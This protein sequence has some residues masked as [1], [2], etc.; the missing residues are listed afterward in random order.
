VGSILARREA[1]IRPFQLGRPLYVSRLERAQIELHLRFLA[2]ADR[3][4]AHGATPKA[5]HQRI[6]LASLLWF[7]GPAV[8]APGRA[9]YL[10]VIL[11]RDFD[12]LSLLWV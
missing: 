5:S 11:F 12:S 1:H 7:P 4:L 2:A 9:A 3:L 6:N 8:L 10:F